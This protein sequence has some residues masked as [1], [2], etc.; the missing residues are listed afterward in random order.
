MLLRNSLGRSL[1]F[2]AV[3]ALFL[4]AASLRAQDNPRI[5]L[6]GG[7]SWYNTPVRVLQFGTIP[8]T[9]TVCPP[10]CAFVNV[11]PNTTLNGWEAQ[12]QYHLLSEYGGSIG[13]VADF[14][15]NYGTVGGSSIHQTT[16]LFGPQISVPKA[17]SPF[18]HVL[19]GWA[20]QSQGF[21]NNPLFLRA[22][23]SDHSF[24]FAFGGGIDF[25]P[26]RH[27]AWRV[28]QVDYM[29]TSFF[30]TGNNGVRLSTGAIFRF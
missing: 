16:Y 27:F 19:L 2:L 25:R 26:V 30:G 5:E 13:I 17:F 9:Q 10:T 23:S 11:H 1:L 24:A 15:G 8:G 7:Y 18:A 20:H 3:G 6:F 12:G 4:C 21:S 28:L 14:G 22:G 29:H